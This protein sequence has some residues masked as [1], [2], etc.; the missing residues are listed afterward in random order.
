MPFRSAAASN[1]GR[2]PR[3][4]HLKGAPDAVPPKCSK[5]QNAET[6]LEQVMSRGPRVIAVARRQMGEVRKDISP[7]EIEKD[8]ELLRLL[9][10]A[11]PPR[12]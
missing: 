8:L 7:G 10:I 2:H 5:Q 9:G 12:P 3:N 11:E 6:P 4:L 1:A